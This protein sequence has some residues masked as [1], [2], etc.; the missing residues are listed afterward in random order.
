LAILANNNAPSTQGEVSILLGQGDGTFVSAGAATL[1]GRGPVGMATADFD[2]SGSADLAVVNQTDASLTILLNH[3]DAT[4]GPGPLSPTATGAG[5]SPTGI[6]VG[7]FDGNGTPDIAVSNSGTNTFSIFLNPG[8]GALALALEPP[9]GTNPSAIVAAP[10][11]G[12]TTADAAIANNL[13]NTPG[14]VTVIL[15]SASFLSRGGAVQQ[16]YP[17][18]EYID[19]GVK[20]KATPVLHANDE[21]TLQLEFEIRALSGSSINGIPIISNRTMTQTVRV[22]EDQPSLLGGLTDREETRAITGLPGFASLPVVGYAFG[23]RSNSSMNTELIFM[24]TPRRLRS[25]TRVERTFYAGRGDAPTR[26]EGGPST[27]Q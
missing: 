26:H 3:G 15:N 21:V 10:L 22:K 7:D 9:G 27:P 18:S 17:G 6:S 1:V 13:A 19:L 16:P 20:V 12:T 2:A 5:T 14:Q 11:A 8:L 25:P 24:I 23:V 4:F